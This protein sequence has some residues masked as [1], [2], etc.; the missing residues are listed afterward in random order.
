MSA[1]SPGAKASS[2]T[3][4]DPASWTSGK[5]NHSPSTGT[6]PRW[7]SS[8]PTPP[9]A[10]CWAY[11]VPEAA[12]RVGRNPETIRRWIRSGRLRAAKVGTQHVIDEADLEP[13]LEDEDA[14]VRERAYLLLCAQHARLDGEAWPVS[15]GPPT[16]LTSYKKLKNRPPKT[17]LINTLLLIC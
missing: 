12:R 7:A 2:P 13:L 11:P 5:A 4:F 8:S 10:E 16:H 6:W 3:C 9:E 14:G 1:S 15:F 17:C